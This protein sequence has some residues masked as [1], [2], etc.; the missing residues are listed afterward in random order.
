[1]D[2]FQPDRE[3]QAKWMNMTSSLLAA[4]AAAVPSRDG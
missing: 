2:G 4:A 1:M 3:Q